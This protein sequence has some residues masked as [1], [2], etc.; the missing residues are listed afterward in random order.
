ML[1]PSLSMMMPFFRN[2]FLEWIMYL[3]SDFV[4]IFVYILY[5][6]ECVVQRAPCLVVCMDHL[7][8]G[9]CLPFAHMFNLSW[10]MCYLKALKFNLLSP[11]TKSMLKPLAFYM[12]VTVFIFLMILSVLFEIQISAVRKLILDEFVWRKGILFI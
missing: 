1:E 6:T 9:T 5:G 10:M 4:I 8:I 7:M 11:W 12:L 2:F 3:T